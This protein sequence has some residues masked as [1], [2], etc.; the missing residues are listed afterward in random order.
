MNNVLSMIALGG[1]QNGDMS[2]LTPVTAYVLIHRTLVLTNTGWTMMQKDEK[3]GCPKCGCDSFYANVFGQQYYT[4]K[5]NL[6][7]T[8][9]TARLKPYSAT[10][11]DIEPHWKD[12]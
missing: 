6:P 12:W 7:A 10:N 11:A 4:P 9:S 3:K 5:A 8:K 1:V 2:A